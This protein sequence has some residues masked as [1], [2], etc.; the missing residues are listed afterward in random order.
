MG[1]KLW[2]APLFEVPFFVNLNE[3]RL[4]RKRHY[5]PYKQLLEGIYQIGILL[6]RIINS[7]TLLFDRSMYPWLQ[8]V[9]IIRMC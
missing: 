6:L 1:V 8:T 3:F 7:S 9:S 2:E 5:D 4:K